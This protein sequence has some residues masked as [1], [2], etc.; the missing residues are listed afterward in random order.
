MTLEFKT[1]SIENPK[2]VNKLGE[3]FEFMR[4]YE[5]D[6]RF[7]IMV[8][9]QDEYGKENKLSL[10]DGELQLSEYISWAGS[11]TDVQVPL[12]L[13]TEDE[14]SVESAL[15]NLVLEWTPENIPD[16]YEPPEF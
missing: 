5:D 3:Q 10:G 16:D 6:I 13:T 15:I 9:Y 2:K 12:L 14:G 7:R 1:N 8:S 4:T 11:K